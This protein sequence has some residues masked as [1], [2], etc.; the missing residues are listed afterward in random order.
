MKK[1]TKVAI[2]LSSVMSCLSAFAGG[3]EVPPPINWDF[4]IGASGVV[5]SYT[6]AISSSVL[7]THPVPRFGAEV[8]VNSPAIYSNVGIIGGFDIGFGIWADRGYFGIEGRYDVGQLGAQEEVLGTITSFV[9]G[10]AAQ[11]VNYP[12]MS[13]HAS[14]VAKIGYQLLPRTMPYMILGWAHVKYSHPARLFGRLFPGI[15]PGT[16]EHSYTSPYKKSLNGGI[17][18]IGVS[19]LLVDGLS[20]FAEFAMVGYHMPRDIYI[21][22]TVKAG[23]TVARATNIYNLEYYHFDMRLGINWSFAS[24]I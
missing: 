10:T 1:S 23:S 9:F 22:Y 8:P 24:L 3:V 18:G 17:M 6:H 14:A 12:T 13:H 2:A 20:A 7:Q 5:Y 15:T 19:H 16:V 21:P 11:F 4:Y